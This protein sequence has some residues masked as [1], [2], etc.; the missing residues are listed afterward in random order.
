[1]G[2]SHMGPTTAST[3][4]ISE[5]QTLAEQLRDG[6]LLDFDQGETLVSALDWA[7]PPGPGSAAAWSNS[8]DAA[9]K[10]LFMAGTG[11]RQAGEELPAEFIVVREYLAELV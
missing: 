5:L 3:M 9:T 4:T 1:M 11:S 7:W 2:G 10:L 6:A 8:W